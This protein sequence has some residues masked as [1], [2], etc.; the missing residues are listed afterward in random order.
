[1][2]E[3]DN[4]DAINFAE[5]LRTNIELLNPIIGEDKKISITASIGVASKMVHHKAITDILRDADHAMYHAKKDGRNRVACLYK[6]CY[7]EQNQSAPVTNDPNE[8][9]QILNINFPKRK[10]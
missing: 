8:R 5:K 9:I 3:T 7:V 6:P 10:E 1:M 4:T 2:P